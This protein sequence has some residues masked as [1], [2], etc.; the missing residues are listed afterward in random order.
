MVGSP[1]SIRALTGSIDGL[2][3]ALQF[4]C[5]RRFTSDRHIRLRWATYRSCRARHS[6]TREEGVANRETRVLAVSWYDGGKLFECGKL[7][8]GRAGGNRTALRQ[9]WRVLGGSAGSTQSVGASRNSFAPLCAGEESICT[10]SR[11][12]AFDPSAPRRGMTNEQ[13]VKGQAESE[14]LRLLK[15]S[16]LSSSFTL[17]SMDFSNG[18]VFVHL[19]ECIPP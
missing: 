3:F 10:T 13:I 11:V 19:R 14:A 7:G 8:R 2:L 5:V 15:P 12:V 16:I 1:A 9:L 6:S 18:S 17:V 4:S